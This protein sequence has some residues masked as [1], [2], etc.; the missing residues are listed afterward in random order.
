MS[1]AYSVYNTELGYCQGM[2]QIAALLL[3]YL[4]EEDAFWALSVLM[5]GN[6]YNMHGEESEIYSGGIRVY[7]VFGVTV[8]PALVEGFGEFPVDPLNS[9]ERFYLDPSESFS[10]A[11]RMCG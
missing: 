11:L 6:K 3:M 9:G 5:A 10:T 2:S 4:N 1:A 8:E 7:H